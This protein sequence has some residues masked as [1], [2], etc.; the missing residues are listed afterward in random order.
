ML[1][2]PDTFQLVLMMALTVC[3]QSFPTE[4]TPPLIHRER[5]QLTN[6][7]NCSQGTLEENVKQDM[8]MT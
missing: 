5:Q 1:R 7:Q 4:T 8:D 6:F 3:D 2:V